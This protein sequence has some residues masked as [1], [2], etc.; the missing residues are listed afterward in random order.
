VIEQNQNS[1]AIA[2]M[3]RTLEVSRA[4]YYAYRTRPTS[5]R[6]LENRLLVQEIRVGPA[7]FEAA[8]N[9]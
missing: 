4:G 6:E 2:M 5:E 8:T 9:V 1:Y 7:A 3:C